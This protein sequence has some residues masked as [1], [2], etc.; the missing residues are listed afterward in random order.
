MAAPALLTT[1]P[2]QIMKHLLAFLVLA[3]AMVSAVLAI[4]PILPPNPNFQKPANGGNKL[5]Y[6]WHFPRPG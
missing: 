1:I 4:R 3:L 5:G 2:L 6:P